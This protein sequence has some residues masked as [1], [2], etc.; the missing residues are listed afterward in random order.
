MVGFP[1]T[2]AGDPSPGRPPGETTPRRCPIC[3][4]GLRGRQTSACS[5]KHRAAKSRRAR[6][7]IPAQDL[8]GLRDG[9]VA[10]LDTLWE[11]KVTLE[12]YLGG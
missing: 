3:G 7:P 1:G 6:V 5:D 9:L 10:M 11:I 12:K 2:I 8:R 4:V